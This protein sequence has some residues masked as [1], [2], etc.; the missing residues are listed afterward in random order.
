[1]VEIA[2]AAIGQPRLIMMDEPGAGLSETESDHLRQII[3]GLPTFCGAQVLLVDHDVDLI[4][5]TCNETLVLDFGSQIAHG[6]TAEVLRDAKVRA[7][8]LGTLTGEA[9]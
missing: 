4:A 3:L 1:M 8:Y 2:R 9:A 5:A 7:A 6:P